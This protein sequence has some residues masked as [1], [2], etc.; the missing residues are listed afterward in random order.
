MESLFSSQKRRNEVRFRLDMTRYD[1]L[2]RFADEWRRI[3]W[4]MA[5]VL[6]LM[7]GFA[8]V[9]ADKL[10]G[11][12][13]PEW[14]VQDWI[15]SPPLKLK[16]LRGKVVL[17]RW[18]TAPECP[19]CRATAP[20]LNE[21]NKEYSARGLQVIGFYHHKGDEPLKLADVKKFAVNFGFE[22]PVAIDPEWKTLHQWWLDQGDHDFTSVSFLIDRKGVIRYIHPGGQYVKGE[23][24]YDTMKSQ[25]EKALADKPTASK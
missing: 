20:A 17:V 18:W 9:A 15:N 22:F 3:G 14:Q 1:K 19:Y 2:T 21:F 7:P 16:E 12:K 5:I 25:I 23:K 24:D 13:P 6:G 8:A 11:T 10:V 4:L